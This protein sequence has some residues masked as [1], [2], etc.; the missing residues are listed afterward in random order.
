MNKCLPSSHGARLPVF[1]PCRIACSGGGSKVLHRRR[2]ASK[3]SLHVTKAASK[4]SVCE[5]VL[6]LEAAADS[7][8]EDVQQLV[9]GLWS[10]QY[11]IPRA[12]VLCASSGL[13]VKTQL[14]NTNPPTGA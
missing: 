10:L 1:S 3:R 5:L 8:Q 6:L 2:P 7:P 14:Y 9:D 13:V 11:L 12:Q 4:I